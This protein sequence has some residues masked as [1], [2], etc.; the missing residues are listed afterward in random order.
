MKT[1]LMLVCALAGC[2]APRPVTPVY[3]A[4]V[5]SPEQMVREQFENASRICTDINVYTRA[6]ER[7]AAVA[8]CL[9]NAGFGPRPVLVEIVPRP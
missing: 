9:R 5:K 8:R 3:T 7:P 6:E 1:A 4:P 2:A